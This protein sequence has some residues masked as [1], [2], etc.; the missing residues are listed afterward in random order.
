MNTMT[1]TVIVPVT[2]MD[3]GY[4]SLEICDEDT[5]LAL[6]GNDMDFGVPRWFALHNSPGPQWRRA[7]R[8]GH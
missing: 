6:R 1:A 5:D 4:S 7:R 3:I 2:G 8:S